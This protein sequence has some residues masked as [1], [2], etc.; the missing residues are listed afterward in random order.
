MTLVDENELIY[1]QEKRRRIFKFL[2]KLIA[3]LVIICIVLVICR[4][5]VKNK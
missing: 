3:V 5:V 1:E 2:I 4:N